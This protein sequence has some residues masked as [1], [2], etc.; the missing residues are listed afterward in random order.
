MKWV[1]LIFLSVL[2]L[3]ARAADRDV[4]RVFPVSPGCQLK[5]E[6][7]SGAITVDEADVAEVRVEAHFEINSEV[8]AAAERLIATLNFTASAEGNTVTVRASDPT[9]KGVRL[10]LREG[11]R[12]KLDCRILVPR[13]CD[14]DLR[15]LDGAINVG[16]LAG[17][18]V[19]R[20]TKGNISVRRIDGSVEAQTQSGEIIVSRCSGALVARTQGGLIRAGT[21]GGRAEL[22][23][24]GGDIEVFAAMGG[25][26]AVAEAGDVTANFPKSLS[27]DA[28]IKTAYGSITAKIDPALDCSVEASSFWGR[29]NLKLPLAIDSGG[30]G[31]GKLTGRLNRGGVRITLYANGGHVTIV[32]GETLFN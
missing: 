3:P 6:F 27:A 30:D 23:N 1:S 20:T 22:H 19:A 14:V 28:R 10:T 4:L 12:L 17:R 2:A 8:E 18:V 29:V 15:T 13:R 21:I 32:P 25:L 24:A 31:T 9:G 7:F 16:S 11:P 26:D 5:V